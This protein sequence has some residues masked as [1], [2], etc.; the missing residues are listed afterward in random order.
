MLETN[1]RLNLTAARSP[2]AL[3]VH[4]L[5]SLTVAPYVR[6]PY[7]D[8][9]SGAGFPA[10]PLAIV[11]GMGVTLVEATA[12][13]ARFLEAAVRELGLS[14]AVITARAE[15]AA[16]RP[17]LRERFESGTCRAV[18][19]GPAAAELLLPFLA[20]GGAAILQRGGPSVEERA[21]LEDAVLVLGGVV[22]AE[23]ALGDNRR[24][25]VVRKLHPTPARFPRR[26]GIP[27]KRPLCS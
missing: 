25:V 1:R 26:T 20:V 21:A 4:L 15:V 17:D 7:V 11:L 5:D 9:G 12:K 10:I 6:E 23:H 13:K 2:Q 22:E 19:V 14:G 27:A 8:V 24:I 3:A 16:H 18:A